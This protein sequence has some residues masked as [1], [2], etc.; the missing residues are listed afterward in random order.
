MALSKHRLKCRE[1]VLSR[2][3]ANDQMWDHSKE[4][5]LT[6]YTYMHMQILIVCISK[7]T[8]RIDERGQESEGEQREVYGRVWRKKRGGRNVVIKLQFQ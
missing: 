2:R 5:S 4:P 1:R 3:L 8:I 7:H 6:A